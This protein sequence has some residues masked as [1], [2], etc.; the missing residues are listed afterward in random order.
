M[1]PPGGGP[2]VLHLFPR[3][4]IPRFYRGKEI[5]LVGDISRGMM[6]IQQSFE[7]LRLVDLFYFLVRGFA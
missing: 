5:C 2:G 3:L 6:L 1:L 7:F 4:K